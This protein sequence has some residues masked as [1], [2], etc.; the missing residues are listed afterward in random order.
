M[1]VSSRYILDILVY[2]KK[3]RYHAYAKKQFR[4]GQLSKELGVDNFVIRF[5]E[6][7]FSLTTTRSKGGQRFYDEDNLYTFKQIK[8]LLYTRKFTISGAK[9]ELTKNKSSSV[10]SASYKTTMNSETPD[11][12]AVQKK[13]SQLKKQLIQLQQML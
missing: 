5:W 8:E 9:H 11:S 3:R 2:A 10:I 6:K 1:L 7:E 13:C 4:I 12:N